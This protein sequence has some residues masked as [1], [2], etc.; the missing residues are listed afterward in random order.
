MVAEVSAPVAGS[1]NYYYYHC[2]KA[3]GLLAAAASWHSCYK[4]G[5][6]EPCKKKVAA[7]AAA[8]AMVDWQMTVEEVFALKVAWISA[9]HQWMAT[10]P[11]CIFSGLLH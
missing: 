3:G 10:P 8:E 9:D 4:P 5:P 2:A 7:A 1:L 6:Q 11:G